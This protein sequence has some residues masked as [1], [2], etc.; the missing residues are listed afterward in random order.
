MLG[1]VRVDCRIPVIAVGTVA[2]VVSRLV[3]LHIGVVRVTVAIAV[4]V[5]VPGGSVQCGV[6]VRGAVAVVVLSVAVLVRAGVGAVI[7]VVTVTIQG[8][9]AIGQVAGH[10]A[11]SGQ[12]E[13]IAVGIFVPGR[14]IDGIVF[15]ELAIAIVILP[16]AVLVRA[17]VG[18]AVRVVAVCVDCH[19]V[20]RLI[21]LHG[22]VVRISE[23]VR[24][25]VV[26]P[27]RSIVGVILVRLAVAVVVHGVAEF[28]RVGVD[29]CVGVV[30]VGVVFDV[31]IGGFAGG[32][33]VS[34]LAEPILV[35]IGI[36]GAGIF[37]GVLVD[38][39]IAVVVDAVAV[40]ERVR[41]DVPIVVVAVLVGGHVVG[42]GVAGFRGVVGIAEAITV[43]I[44]VP[45]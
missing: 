25:S 45:G 35:C 20:G 10:V 39:V 40:L 21:A 30:A 8:D 29:G 34:A 18:V 23:E 38:R 37:C 32:L 27:G 5:C 4:G 42:G 1:R 24:V 12:T 26:V 13:A 44:H 9:V 22:A 17:G 3:A 16:I 2:G 36:P 19:V 11:R 6:L 43:R 7:A 33:G 14:G 31:A 28:D 15:V 41:T